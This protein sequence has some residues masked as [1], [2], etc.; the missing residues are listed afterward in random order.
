M[1]RFSLLFAAL[2]I[3]AFVTVNAQEKPAEPLK[4][5]FSAYG[6][7]GFNYDAT[8]GTSP[9]TR[10][11]TRAARLNI[12]GK[13]YDKIGFGA[14]ME[15]SGTPTMTQA[16]M[17]YNADKLLNIRAGQ[18]KY[19]FGMEQY[20]SLFVWKFTNLSYIHD[21]FTRSMGMNGA[22]FRDQGVQVSGEYK[23]NDAF[24]PYYKVMVMNGTGA[25]AN[26]NNNQ[27]DIVAQ[28]GAKFM[29]DFEANFSYLNGRNGVSGQFAET[30]FNVFLGYKTKTI[31]AQAEYLSSSVEV[32]AG[33]GTYTAKPQGYYLYATGKV[34]DN[35]ELGVRYDVYDRDKEATVDNDLSRATVLVGYYFDDFQKITLNYEFRDD[36][37]NTKLGNLLMLTAYIGLQ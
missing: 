31:Q 35:V 16:F 5:N 6:L 28:F 10:F 19:P 4:I 23:M 3:G 37:A 11:L 20:P 33:P 24:S 13:F 8:E 1:K 27:K 36:K 34:L 12:S 7:I 30:A 32:A 9:D 22:M 18:F 21:L 17:D 15:L 2:L 14:Q 26:D 29:K 25:N